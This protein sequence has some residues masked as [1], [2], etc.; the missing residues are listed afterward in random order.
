MVLIGVFVASLS[1]VIEVSSDDVVGSVKNYIEQRFNLL[2]KKIN[3]KNNKSN[4]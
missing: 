1:S 3:K 2:E 4:N